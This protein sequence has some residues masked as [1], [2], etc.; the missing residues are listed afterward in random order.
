MWRAMAAAVM[1]AALAGAERIVAVDIN[2]DKLAFAPGY[3]ATDV[4]D[5][6]AA[7]VADLVAE[8]TGGSMRFLKAVMVC[9]NLPGHTLRPPPDP[10]F[11]SE[12]ESALSHL[13]TPLANQ[14]AGTA[15]SL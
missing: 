5:A 12:I 4:V 6:S 8:L 3:G 15:E 7:D 2:A 1:G 11:T 14:L 10:E 13:D 9:A